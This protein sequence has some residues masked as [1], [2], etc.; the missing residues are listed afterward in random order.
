MINRLFGT[1][2]LVV[3]TSVAMFA[4]VT[5]VLASILLLIAIQGSHYV[6]ET[7]T[8]KLTAGQ[9]ML[10]AL[11]QRQSRELQSQVAILA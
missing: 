2:R 9:R 6:R 1:P 7:V 3:R 5:I 8:D 10:S 4:V 11:E